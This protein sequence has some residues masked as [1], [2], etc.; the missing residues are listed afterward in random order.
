MVL[1]G[2]SRMTEVADSPAMLLGNI[3]TMAAKKNQSMNQLGIASANY[4]TQN[5]RNLQSSLRMGQAGVS[6]VAIR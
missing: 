1:R 6:K 2:I 5:Q 3:A 4:Y